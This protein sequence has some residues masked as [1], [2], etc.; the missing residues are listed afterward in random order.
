MRSSYL[1]PWVL[2][3]GMGRRGPKSYIAG[4]RFGRLI[5]IGP[6]GQTVRKNYI[7]SCQC[8]CGNVTNVPTA[9]LKS[10]GTHSCGCLRRDLRDSK[11][12]PEGARLYRSYASGAKTRELDFH[13][14]CSEF[15]LLIGLDCVYCGARPA[16][17]ARFGSFMS[18]GVDRVDSSQ[19][20]VFGN[21]VPCCSACNASKTD[22]P[23]VDYLRWL[24]RAARHMFGKKMSD[25]TVQEVVDFSG[26]AISLIAAAIKLYP[27]LAGF[28]RGLADGKTDPV[29][30]KVASILPEESASRTAQHTLGG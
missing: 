23:L 10:G 20:Y 12:V 1:L 19:G 6:V 16:R 29:S 2:S 24:Q 30:L 15:C 18:N 22:T 8:D 7:W 9:T 21:V 5:A 3:A 14:S 4:Q 25:N 11:K 17:R 27:E 13:I 28:L 26:I